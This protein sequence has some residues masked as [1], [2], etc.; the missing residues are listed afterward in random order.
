M[1]VKNRILSL[2]LVACM[3][4]TLLPASVLAAAQATRPQA[5]QPMNPESEKLETPNAALTQALEANQPRQAEAAAV[6]VREVENPGVDLK[7][8]LPEEQLPEAIAY[9]KDEAVRVIMVLEEQSLLDQGFS[10]AQIASHD[11]DAVRQEEAMARRQEQVLQT[12]R[13][14]VDEPVEVK[15]AYSV[16]VSGMALEIPY[17]DLEEI[18]R[19]PGVKAAFVAPQYQVP[20]DMSG[21]TSAPSMHATTGS[22]GAVTTWE[23]LGYTGQ[24]MRV[25]VIDTGLD[26]DH[27]SF[28]AA[29]ALTEDSLTA[30]KLGGVL[31]SLNAYARY[32][33]HSAV[34]L[35]ADKLYRSEK[36]PYGFNYVDESLDITHD[37]DEQGDHGTHVSGT[38]AANRTEGTEVV[39][40]A[41][42][43]QILV[44]KVFGTNG[45]AYFD[46]ILAALEDSFR[47]NA[48]AVN[49]SLGS[50]AGF[51]DAGELV[52]EIY[53]KILDSDMIAAIAAGNSASAAAGNGFGTDR[54][55]TKDPDNGIVSSPATYV[56]ATVVASME[57]ES[58]MCNYFTVGQERV[59]F[60]DV[61]AS[62]FT[63]LAGEPLPYVLVPGYGTAE[64]FA[65]VDVA[66]KVAVVSRGELAFTDKQQNAHT[67]GAMALVVFDNAEGSLTNMQDAQ[68]LPN[69]FVSK[70]SGEILAAAAE[71]GQGSL[72]V[73]PADDRITVESATAGQ[74][75]DFSS[76]GVT[77]DLKLVPDITAPGGN[78]Y[79]TLDG[80]KY[81]TM[82]GTSMAT[83]H[84]AGM[85]ALVLEYLRDRFDLTEAQA[86][87]VAEA[88]LMST[89]EPV[90]EPGGILYSPR[91]QGSGSAN[92]YKA[93]TSPAYLTVNGGTP[94]VSLGDDDS[95]AGV[96][97]FSFEVNNLTDEPR[98]YVLD[99]STL[100]DQV[101]LT[102]AGY[103]YQFMGETARNL[104]ASVSFSV[105]N[106]QIP[107]QYDYN[108]DGRTDMEDVQALLDAVNGLSEIR[109]GFDLNGDGKID[110][111]DAQA[112]YE[113]VSSGSTAIGVVEVP[114]NG[115]TTV[116][117]TVTLSDADKAYMDMYYENGIYVDGFVRLYAQGEGVDLS[118]PFMGFYG[119]W[120]DARVF[121]SGWYY[122]DAPEVNRYLNVLFTNF[123]A[124][125]YALGLNP[126]LDE[127][128]DPS[129]NVLSANGDGYLDR[130]SE[131]YLSMMR[132]AKEVRFTWENETTGETLYDQS[133]ALIR[134]SYYNNAYG[135]CIPFIVSQEMDLYD[136]E[137]LRDGTDLKLTINAW[138]DDGDQQADDT[139][140]VPVHIDNEAPVLYTDEIAYLYNPYADTRRLEFY[141]SDNYGIAAVI[142]LTDAQDA[143]QAIAIDN[144]PGEKT[145]VSLDVTHY[146]SKFLLAVCDYG[147]NETYY[148]VSF[149][150][151]HDVN[152]G[153]FYGYRRFSVVPNGNY[154]YATDG[155]NG[156]YSF[157]AADSMLQH[158]AQYSSGETPVAAAEYV[159]GYILG[160]DTGSAIFA[161]KAG[162]WNRTEIG[163]LELDG[164]AYSALD[165]AFDYTT[166]TLFILTDELAE[167][168]G[169]HLVALDYL[170]GGLTDLGVVTGI[171][172]GSA[173]GV[174]LACDNEGVLYTVDYTTGALYTINKS[175][176][177]ASY[178][179]E[180]G[181][182][183]LY[184]QSMTVDHET[185][186]LYWSAYQGQT[187]DSNFY[188]VD[189]AT[190]ELTFLADVEYNGAMTGL[191]KPSRPGK[192][193]L[194]TDAALDHLLLSETSLMMC[195][196]G[197]TKLLCQP[198][199]YYAALGDVSWSSSNAEVASVQ[200]GVVTALGEG[201]TVITASVGAQSVSCTVTV[202]K[203]SS[204]L[205]LYDGGNSSQWLSLNAAAPQDA[206]VVQ[207]GTTSKNGI[208]S[209]AYYNGFVYAGDYGGGFYRLNAETLQ[210]SQLGSSDTNLVAMAMNYSD[211]FLYG[212]ELEESAWES[213]YYL[214]RV[215]PSNGEVRRLE[216]FDTS[217]LG[218][219]LGGMAIDYEGNFYS[220]SMSSVSYTCMLVKFQ[221]IG[222]AITGVE[223]ASMADWPT[224]SFG[225]M[226]YSGSSDGIFWAN[227]SGDLMWIDN[228]HMDNVKVVRL[229][230]IAGTA[231]QA[232]NMGLLEIPETEPEVPY[233]EPESVAIPKSYLLLEGGSVSANLSVEPWNASVEALY[234]V[235]DP[236][237]ATVDADGILTGVSAGK[238]NLSIYV[239]SL[240][241][242]LEA[243]VEVVAPAGNLYGFLLSDFKYGS[244]FWIRVQDSDPSMLEATSSGTSDFS[245]FSG[246]YYNGAIYAYGQGGEAYHY[247]CYFLKINPT[248]YSIEV[249]QQVHYSLR[250]MEFDYTTGTLYAIAKGG[251]VRGA[252]AQVDVKTGH[253]ALVGNS[254]LTLAAMTIDGEGRIY[255]IAEDGYLYQLDR[256]T[257]EATQ[258]G[259]TGVKSV[260]LFQS[261]HY[262]HNSGNTYWAQI[263][264][265]RSNS[266]RLVDITTGVTTSLGQVGP[267]GAQMS[268]LFTVPQAAPALP[269]IVEP[270]GVSLEEQNTVSVG[271]TVS[272][273]A[274]VLPFSV[275]SVDQSLTWTTSDPRIATVEDGMVTGVSAGV[276]TVTATTTHGQSAACT[277]YVTENQRKFYAYDE[278]N[279]QWIS[280]SA[281]DPTAVA[282][283]RADAEGE[284][285]IAA[286]AY[287][288][289]ALY[290]YDADGR[291]YT[292]DPGTFVRTKVGDAL[293]GKTITT[294]LPSWGG[295][296]EV[297]CQI[298]PVDLSYDADSGKLYA[299]L[300]A[301]NDESYAY[302]SL[303]GEVDLA[304]GEVEVLHQSAD[305]RPGNLLVLNG[306]AFF[307]DAYV[308]GMLRVLD[309]NVEGAIP[310][311]LAL[312]QGYWGDTQGGRSFLEDAYTGTVYA[313]RDLQGGKSTL[314]ILN[315][316]DADIQPLGSIGSGIVVNSLF[317]R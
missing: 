89:A 101:D 316:G 184:Q 254:G 59:A 2:L 125:D 165:M 231:G 261:M 109:S 196:G 114:A 269:E 78:I 15:Y 92:V 183:P 70:A 94:K 97:R 40:I 290:A 248:D 229:G 266:L 124:S 166:D 285:A 83:P 217:V 307:V 281:E 13:Q 301:Y 187:G 176:A 148:E 102:Y 218:T 292:V 5:M 27:P 75:S 312:V 171:Q 308:S 288:G 162:S 164:Q 82:S 211:G 252:L 247:K 73:H 177:K 317:I 31:E 16:A 56:G 154:L 273:S 197:T 71:N 127:T 279:T 246:A 294:E 53:G 189:K 115:A 116:N 93:V 314:N 122:E 228:S 238:T 42:D 3:L 58:V 54:N 303:I 157:E 10:T 226:V 168:Q 255:T 79:S 258:I 296:R 111:A 188:E 220:V 282:V 178:V 145:L 147:C 123:G 275:A 265:D 60:S 240:G 191:F 95:R 55:L 235:K 232:M 233:V 39:G 8:N 223:T 46:D 234:S 227:E 225:S 64:D 11:A 237:V 28:A 134:K 257:G 6:T 172:G 304:T 9:E 180:T 190:G 131:I 38:V 151:Q 264:K 67:A 139:V 20:E 259:H 215:N 222:D 48:D 272:L 119:D 267:N 52:N 133:A 41:P 302:V 175:N 315:L 150:G 18:R 182:K 311:D 194:P 19:I 298:R 100:T 239:A 22:V 221:V 185:D 43:A 283:E 37:N 57:N 140:T 251:T 219:P 214:V 268:A 63:N 136:F 85:S 277:V 195:V 198:W 245:V 108:T 193:L 289:E 244:D 36:I 230:S 156:W 87:T 105:S 26:T 144:V 86:H 152:Y 173:Q 88:L 49:M 62:P 262:D 69:V 103:G 149:S 21:E 120:S 1:K 186:R 129:H 51:C 25:A 249:L 163:R 160:V 208:L 138:L 50:P 300:E 310:R 142:P 224:Y 126:Y 118:L 81:G 110:T 299:A 206:Q 260:G 137:G 66:G 17:G 76:W 74:M 96:Y 159:D 256:T 242:T 4:V 271:K 29:P 65:Q 253:V 169:G 291:F 141:V 14:A 241:E 213:N 313:I 99:A 104:D 34:K 106:G 47:L 61:A 201:E 286:S 205:R 270:T 287:T 135:I 24:G 250:D 295:T 297:E 130:V 263:G 207:G 179:G 305:I 107:V 284:A 68:L 174:T 210:G 161:M 117:I 209:A 143:F 45:G 170:T 153:A 203:F 44:M 202:S 181:Y 158:T 132:G 212:L 274:Y 276:V 35:T 128:Y 80:G 7:Q 199:P 236:S 32:M 192:A 204:E 121:D 72:T 112:L 91:K 243:S 200:G 293:Y 280:F 30:E 84:I 309:L 113:L 216:S 12:I 278:T 33:S 306:S 155:L 167:G 146:D 90:V 77:P 98:S 23:E